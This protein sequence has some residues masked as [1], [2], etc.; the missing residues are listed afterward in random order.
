M[1]LHDIRVVPM[2]VSIEQATANNPD[3]KYVHIDYVE[4]DPTFPLVKRSGDNDDLVQRPNADFFISDRSPRVGQ[5]VTFTD[6]S[7][8][9]YDSW[10]WHFG[11]HTNI[12]RGRAQGPGPYH[13]TFHRRGT[14]EIKLRVWGAGAGA[15]HVT[16]TITVH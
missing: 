4:T 9:Q 6:E 2:D 10:L 13:V 8:G 15:D 12:H 5:H 11:T 3:L 1:L 7:T 14:H 16:K